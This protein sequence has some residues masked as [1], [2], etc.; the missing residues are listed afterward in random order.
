MNIFQYCNQENLDT[1]KESIHMPIG[2]ARAR[3]ERKQFID[4][5]RWIKTFHH[6][7]KECKVIEGRFERNNMYL[8]RFNYLTIGEQPLIEILEQ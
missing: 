3:Y 5:L 6:N 2:L 7:M 1:R 8:I 4:I